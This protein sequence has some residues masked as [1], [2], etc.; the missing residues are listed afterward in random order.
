MRRQLNWTHGK[1]SRVRDDEESGFVLRVDGRRRGRPRR[2][3][4]V[5]RDLAGAGGQQHS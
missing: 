3:D 5:K 1:N 4:S 2:E